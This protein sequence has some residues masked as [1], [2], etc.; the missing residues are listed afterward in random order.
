[1]PVKS[2]LIEKHRCRV[3]LKP[4]ES[5]AEAQDTEIK[6]ISN[7]DQC[8]LYICINPQ[9]RSIE[10]VFIF[11]NVIGVSDGLDSS[12]TQCQSEYSTSGWKRVALSVRLLL[13]V[14]ELPGRVLNLKLEIELKK[15]KA[16]IVSVIVHLPRGLI[17]FVSNILSDIGIGLFWDTGPNNNIV[18]VWKFWVLEQFCTFLSPALP[19][20][21][22][23]NVPQHTKGNQCESLCLSETVNSLTVNPDRGSFYLLPRCCPDTA[24]VSD[25]ML[26]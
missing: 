8:Y 2:T 20:V 6:C 11:V 7:T 1:M 16:E 15:T 21:P 10:W 4:Q 19:P 3:L 18:F 13:R 23:L 22:S 17:N 9:T 26:W 14:I 12:H 24:H 5:E 25:V